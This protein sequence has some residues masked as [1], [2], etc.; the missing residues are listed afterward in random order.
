MRPYTVIEG[1]TLRLN[2]ETKVEVVKLSFDGSVCISN[3][4]QI[5]SSKLDSYCFLELDLKIQVCQYLVKTYGVIL[6]Y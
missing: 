5:E 2:T 6:K 4:S 3:V 1:H